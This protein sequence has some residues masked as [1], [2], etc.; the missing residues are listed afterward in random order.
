MLSGIFQHN[1]DEKGR[2]F[3]PAKWR[4]DLKERF[5]ITKGLRR[6]VYIYSNEQW[7]TIR[8]KISALPYTKATN[9]R[10]HFFPY[11][12]EVEFDRQGRIVVSAELR[13]F[14]GIKDEKS[15]KVVGNDDHAEIWNIDDWEEHEREVSSRNILEQMDLA[16]F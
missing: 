1:I 6:C 10:D 9:L 12:K 3:I 16:G 8:E 13:E 11:A 5:V 7:N 2:L 4:D 14:A 15:V